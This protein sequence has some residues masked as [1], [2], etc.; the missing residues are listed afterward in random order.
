MRKILITGGA[1]FIGANLAKKLLVE[2]NK[3]FV[4]DSFITSSH[5]NVL[6][7][8]ENPNF[9]LINYDINKGLIFLSKKIPEIH[10]IYHLA[11]PT[12]VENL[13]P[14]AEE[15]LLTSSIGTRNVLNFGL[16]TKAKVIFSSS[17]EVYGD[18]E[19]SPQKESYWGNV[20]QLGVRSPYEEGKRFSESLIKMYIN[21]YSLN[22]KIA[23]V[24]NTYGPGMI[25]SDT[26]VIPQMMKSVLYGN[27]ILI[28]G[29][30]NQKRT[31]C[32]I[33]DLTD[34]LITILR[35]GESGEAYNVG[36][37]K[38]ISINQLAELILKISGVNEK[39]IH[40]KNTIEDHKSRMPDLKKIKK[41]GWISNI[42]LEEGLLKTFD[43]YLLEPNY[44]MGFSFKH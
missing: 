14:L 10:E 40:E 18:P 42:D 22:A 8:Q 12:G 9:T 1:G 5:R 27:P 23:R 29:D 43:S 33:D 7:L 34:G 32:Y 25:F 37:N 28:K 24:F 11:C 44:E 21:K 15:M 36:S 2:G 20:N 3:V 19:L 31:F 17:S 35:K 4:I 30:G 6:K 16:I 41:L 26:R 13:I 38:Q 39:V